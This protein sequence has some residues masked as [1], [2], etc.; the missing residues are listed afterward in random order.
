MTEVT[1]VQCPLCGVPHRAAAVKCDSCGQPLHVLP[2]TEGMEKECRRRK[3]EM[4]GAAAA[5]AAMI[6]LNEL[7]FRGD[8]FILALAPFGWILWSGRR[9]YALRRGLAR[10]RGR[11]SALQE[12]HV[13]QQRRSVDDQQLRP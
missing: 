11:G 5:I 3:L 12:G 6:A 4:A 1:I 9:L 13:L 8:A 2:D 10:V 7:M